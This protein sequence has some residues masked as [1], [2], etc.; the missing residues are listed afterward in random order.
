MNPRLIFWRRIAVTSYVLLILFVAT[1]FFI[2]SPPQNKTFALLS[3][4]Y[5]LLLFLPSKQLIDNNPRVYMWSG[6]LILLYFTHA[7]VE[8][9]ANTEE[10]GYALVELALTIIY[11]ISATYCYRYSRQKSKTGHQT[12]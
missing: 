10:R 9:Y 2:I 5:L 8:S 6:Y 7:V 4:V 12:K 1:W 11:F 3:S